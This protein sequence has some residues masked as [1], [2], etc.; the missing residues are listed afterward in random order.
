MIRLTILRLCAATV[1]P[2]L[3]LAT[4]PALAQDAAPVADIVLVEDGEGSGNSG[5]LAVNLAAGTVN[6]QLN[7]AAVAVGTVA[8][9]GQHDIQTIRGSD[10]PS[11]TATR[12]VIGEDA[13]SDNHGLVSVNVTAGTANQSAN[14][15]RLA[16]GTSGALSDSSLEQSRALTEPNGAPVG[17]AGESNDAV[18]I[19]DGA[20]GESS[21]LLQVNL[22]GGERNSSANTFSLN[23]SAGKQP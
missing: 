12:L 14:L 1:L 5:R 17:K 16:I 10:H 13:F 2:T 19:G 6:Q 9:V 22:I 21:G 8:M 11:D 15:A 3:A 4:S 20:F 23:V 7:D 18:D